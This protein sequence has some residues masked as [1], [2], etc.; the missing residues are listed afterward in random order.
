MPSQSSPSQIP[1]GQALSG[2]A[3]MLWFSLGSLGGGGNCS[4]QCPVSAPTST[5]TSFPGRTRVYQPSRG[6]RRSLASPLIGGVSHLKL[7]L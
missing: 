3:P 7:G 5:S 4:S 2:G 1:E 6:S